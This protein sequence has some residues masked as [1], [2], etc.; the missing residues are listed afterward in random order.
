MWSLETL[1]QINAKH[2]ELGRDGKPVDA[3]AVYRECGI[4]VLGNTYTPPIRPMRVPLRVVPATDEQIAAM[5]PELSAEERL[6]LML[7]AIGDQ[8][9]QLFKGKPKDRGYLPGLW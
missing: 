6:E 8:V 7:G 9:E 3:D 5:Y 4:R 2:A 1:Q